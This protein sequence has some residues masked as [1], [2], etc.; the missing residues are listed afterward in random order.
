[1]HFPPSSSRFLAKHFKCSVFSS[2]SQTP[3]V[4]LHLSLQKSW[5]LLQPSP[6]GL[7]G[8][9]D[10]LTKITEVCSSRSS[11]GLGSG[12]GVFLRSHGPWGCAFPSPFLSQAQLQPPLLAPSSHP[13]LPFHSQNYQIRR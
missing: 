3:R 12:V 1:M 13:T 9:R 8:S 7:A 11:W 6:K 2:V 5:D 4:S 10:N